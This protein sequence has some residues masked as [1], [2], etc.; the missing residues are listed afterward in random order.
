MKRMQLK[1]L[2][3]KH[4]RNLSDKGDL[5]M[6]NKFARGMHPEKFEAPPNKTNGNREELRLPTV[7]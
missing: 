2:S 6:F 7:K 4:S 5:P 3:P 1:S